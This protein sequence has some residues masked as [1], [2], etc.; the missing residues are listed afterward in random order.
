VVVVVTKVKKKFLIVVLL[1]FSAHNAFAEMMEKGKTKVKTLF[2]FYNQSSKGGKQ[3]FDNSGNENVTVIEPQIFIKHQINENTEINAN[4]VLDTWTA[5]SDTIL[6][7]KTGASGDEEGITGQARF[8]PNFGI[9]KEIGKTSMG[10]NLGFSSE[11][12]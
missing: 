7:G 2:N 9:R 12:D 10:L 6:D 4:F 8:A 11:Y 1:C 3:V 5:E